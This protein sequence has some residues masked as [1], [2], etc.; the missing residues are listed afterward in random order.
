MTK[1]TLAAKPAIDRIKLADGGTYTLS[2]INLNVMV[3]VEDA[4]NEP[5][6]KLL[7]SGAVKPIRYILYLR[8]RR[9]YPD[10][11]EEQVGALVDADVLVEIGKVLGM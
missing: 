3:E 10:M 5:I 1:K 9:D 4:F 8:L 2:P 11:T 6:A 7:E